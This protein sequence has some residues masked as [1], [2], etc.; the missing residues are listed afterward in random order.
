[1]QILYSRQLIMRLYFYIEDLTKD[2][3]EVDEK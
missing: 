1:M 2:E 3:S